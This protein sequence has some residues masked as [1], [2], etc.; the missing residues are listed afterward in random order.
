MPL[1]HE[2]EAEE[3][4]LGGARFQEVEKPLLS[5]GGAVQKRFLDR[6]DVYGDVVPELHAAAAAAAA[7]V[8][9]TGAEFNLFVWR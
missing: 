4:V 5:I 2:A 3:P 6:W 1:C 8:V 7:A 9:V